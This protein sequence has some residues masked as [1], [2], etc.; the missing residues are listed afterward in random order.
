MPVITINGPIG[1]GAADIGQMV[2]EKLEIDF[3]DRLILTEASKLVRAPVGALIDKEQRIASF[4]DRLG[5]FMVTMLERSVL[6]GG[7]YSGGALMTLPPEAFDSL[8]GDASA[9]ITTVQDKD[10]IE[11]TTTVVNDLS[12]KGNVVIVG[13]GANMILA[14]TPG[15][16]H[17]GLIAPMEV[18]A[19]NLMQRENLEREEAEN[20]VKELE[21]AHVTYFRK[22]FQVHPSEPGLYHTILNMGKLRQVTAAEIIV[23][24]SEDLDSTRQTNGEAPSDAEGLL[25]GRG[26]Q[27][28]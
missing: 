21:S 4:R 1:C 13:R 18:R 20:F 14:D 27:G 19:E 5:R 17:V 12:Q 15:V 23:Q 3:V 28:T 6:S 9:K 26:E 2:A 25:S 24:A 22:F 10:F 8:E 16:F 11:A 7:M